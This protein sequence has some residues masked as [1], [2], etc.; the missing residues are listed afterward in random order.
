MSLADFE[1][2]HFII[3]VFIVDSFNLFGLIELDF[4]VKVQ[5]LS[6]VNTVEKTDYPFLRRKN[7]ERDKLTRCSVNAFRTVRKYVT[8]SESSKYVIFARKRTKFRI[9]T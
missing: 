8:E 7:N 6:S 4:N 3:A 9:I 2:L 5:S 1:S